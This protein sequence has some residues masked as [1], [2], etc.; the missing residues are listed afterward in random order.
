MDEV[1]SGELVA[2]A[3]LATITF[4]L[5]VPDLLD[6]EQPSIATSH[7]VLPE[8]ERRA[9][10]A[11]LEFA[12]VGLLQDR[13]VLALAQ[14]TLTRRGKGSGDHGSHLGRGALWSVS[15]DCL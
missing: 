6:L 11:A 3:A 14:Q 4:G 7:V 15:P 13:A 9:P 12:S 1:D 2:A 5:G 10:S 8:L